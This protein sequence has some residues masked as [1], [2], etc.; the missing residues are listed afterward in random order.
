MRATTLI[1]LAALFAA[2]WLLTSCSEPVPAFQKRLETLRIAVIPD[3]RLS[4]DLQDIRPLFNHLADAVALPYRAIIPK[5][6]ED[7]R[8]LFA[9]GE[10]DLAWFGALDYLRIKACCNA[11]PIAMRDIDA[12]VTTLLL[13]RADLNLD[14][15]DPYRGRE[16]AFGP[17]DT[18]SGHLMARH[19][20][21]A[22]NGIRP[23]DR[24]RRTRYAESQKQALIWARDGVVEM[25]TACSRVVRRMTNEG[26]LNSKQ[27]KLLWETPPFPAH[28]WA[29]RADLPDEIHRTLSRA[30][31]ALSTLDPKHTPILNALK[32]EGFLPVESGAFQPLQETARHQGL[33]P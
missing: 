19:F 21:E 26:Q 6:R 32:T 2:H 29:A 14:P 15:E 1:T 4:L 20:M 8:M 7:L 22:E 27:L 3:D 30:F 10:I 9:N 13:A 23:E 17:R 16:I 5:S 28:V 24:F 31:L 12:Q 25:A 18:T 11:N 33:I